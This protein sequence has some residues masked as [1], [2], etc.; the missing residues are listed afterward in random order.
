MPATIHSQIVKR[1]STAL[2]NKNVLRKPATHEAS[3]PKVRRRFLDYLRIAF[4][5]PA[6]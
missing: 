1:P 2:E 5:A 6:A 4:S 3:A